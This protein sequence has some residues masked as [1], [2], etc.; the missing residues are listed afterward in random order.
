METNTGVLGSSRLVSLDALRGFTVAGM[1]VVNVPGS[2]AHVYS[3]LL[4]APWHGFTPTDLVYP[5]FLYIVG[6]SVAIAYTRQQAAGKDKGGMMKKIF[7]RSLKI[8]GLGLFL[9]LFPGFDFAGVRIPGVL[10]RIALVFLAC[11]LLFLNTNWKQQAWVAG[12]TL[13]AYWVLMALVPVPIDAVIQEALETGQTLRSSGKVPVE[14]LKQLGDGFIA[15]NLEPGT[16]LAAWLDR[17]LIPGRM[18]ERTW[19]PEGVLS[20]FPA[21]VTGILGML[22]GRLILS[23]LPQEHKIIWLFAAGFG[24]FLAGTVWDWFFPINKPIWTSS[25]VLYTAGL[26]SMSFAACIWLVDVKG[27]SHWTKIG[28]VFGSNAVVAYVLH[29]ILLDFFGLFGLELR[30]LFYD[31]LVG[32][33]LPEKLS[34]FGWALFY[35]LVLCYVPVWLLWRKKIFIKL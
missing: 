25:Y 12:G 6:V 30:P 32:L 34:S 1:I 28:V 11:G 22:A 3:P 7:I 27:Y 2:W 13:L 5:F 8:F 29:G 20:T 35:S 14:G 23:K 21:I 26:A 16:N 17:L 10:Q 19:D 15:A 18:W 9:W 24:G 31:G 4:H 33:G